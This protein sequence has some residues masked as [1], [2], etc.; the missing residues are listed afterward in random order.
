MT[1]RKTATIS[2]RK[3]SA[4]H[5]RTNSIRTSIRETHDSAEGIRAHPAALPAHVPWKCAPWF[6]VSG[7]RELEPLAYRV[8]LV[9]TEGMSSA[10]T[11]NTKRGRPSGRTKDRPMQMRV[12][13]EFIAEIDDWRRKQPD[14]PNRTEAIRWMVAQVLASS[15]KR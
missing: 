12:T 7:G 13:D 2:Q 4:T 8:F 14:L 10:N 11:K 1:A 3:T 9:Y 5:K 6:R 15:R